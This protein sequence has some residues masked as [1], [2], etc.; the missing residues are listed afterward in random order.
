MNLKTCGAC[1][2]RVD[3]DAG[4]HVHDPKDCPGCDQKLP[5]SAFPL[6]PSSVDGRRK[7]C[8]DCS[9]GIRKTQSADLRAAKQAAREADR[10]AESAA[11]RDLGYRWVRRYEPDGTW[12][13]ILLNRAGLEVSKE[14]ALAEVRDR[15]LE[16]M[17]DF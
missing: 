6:W 2:Q 7:T 11:L 16:D 15:A 10:E 8:A 14:S 9:K 17:P 1:K 4:P 5:A 3:V 13:W 12:A